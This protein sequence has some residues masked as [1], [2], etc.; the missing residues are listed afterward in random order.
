MLTHSQVARTGAITHGTW[1]GFGL[2]LNSL[3]ETF[4]RAQHSMFTQR[5]GQSLNSSVPI[6]RSWTSSLDSKEPI[7]NYM[8]CT[9][10]QQ[11][12][13]DS[14]LHCQHLGYKMFSISSILPLSPFLPRETSPLIHV[15]TLRVADAMSHMWLLGVWN[16][17]RTPQRD[18]AGFRRPQ[19]SVNQGVGASRSVPV[20][21]LGWIQHL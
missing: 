11:L 6:F 8:E 14:W 3:F 12:H 18:A 13:T 15:A 21:C 16:C 1:I 7:F 2:S 17:K 19:H 10:I 9:K 5:S 20:R 4:L